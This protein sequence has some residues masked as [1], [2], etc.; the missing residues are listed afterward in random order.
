MYFRPMAQLI[1]R[2]PGMIKHVQAVVELWTKSLLLA[3]TDSPISSHTLCTQS[4]T[5]QFNPVS[6]AIRPLQERL[7]TA[8]AGFFR[9]TCTNP[10][11][12]PL[13]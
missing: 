6:G 8:H 11:E 13:A 1:S 9:K 3:T 10:R 12:M 7:T 4:A 2:M 5:K